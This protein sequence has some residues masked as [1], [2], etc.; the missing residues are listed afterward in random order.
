MAL[1]SVNNLCM[2]F[3]GPKLLDGITF[4]IEPGQRVCLVGDWV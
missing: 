1:I 3:G 4:Q 2:S